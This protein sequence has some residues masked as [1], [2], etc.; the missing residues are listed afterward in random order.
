MIGIVEYIAGDGICKWQ[1]ILAED[2]KKDAQWKVSDA[3]FIICNTCGV[4]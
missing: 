1:V 2:V 4:S 3:H